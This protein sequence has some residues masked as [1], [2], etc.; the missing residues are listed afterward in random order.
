MVI[1]D[2]LGAG[3][4]P[5]KDFSL[6]M[7]KV[8]AAL[9]EVGAKDHSAA[10]ICACWRWPFRMEKESRR[11]KGQ[12][13]GAYFSA[14]WGKGFGYDP[15]FVPDEYDITFAQMGKRKNMPCHTGHG[16]LRSF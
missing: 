15:I 1:G 10:F 4:G 8:E 13:R 6:A 9:K 16:L 14:A 5:E 3:P 2:L 12:L 7:G 11:L